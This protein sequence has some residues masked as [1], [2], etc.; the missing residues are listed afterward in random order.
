MASRTGVARPRRGAPREET[1]LLNRELSWVE[2]NGRVLELARDER[3][4]LLERHALPRDLLVEPRRV[5]HGARRRPARARARRHGPAAGAGRALAR[6]GARRD[7]RAHRPADPRAE[8]RARRAAAR[9]RPPRHAARLAGG[10]RRRRARRARRGLPGRDLPRA[11]ARWPSGRDAPSPT[12]RTSR[13]RS[14]CS[15][16]T[17]SRATGASR[18]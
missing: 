4:P 13:S 6:R 11:D 15:C 17:R 14:A 8:P 10:L 16:A 5:L 9:A 18:A 1:R 7:R 3:M 2:F 12:S